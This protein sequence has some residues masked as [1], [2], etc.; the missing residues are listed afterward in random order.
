MKA[1]SERMTQVDLYFTNAM[2]Q[3]M[4]NDEN[5]LTFKQ[6]DH[7]SFLQWPE[8]E[9]SQKCLLNDHHEQIIAIDIDGDT[10]MKY[11]IV[12]EAKKT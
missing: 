4:Q 10:V 11:S 12:S 8:Q 2:C 5:A 7:L 9:A 1:F 3:N 6:G